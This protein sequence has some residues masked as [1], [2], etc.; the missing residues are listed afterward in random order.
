MNIYMVPNKKRREKKWCMK[1]NTRGR[2]GIL[3]R[4]PEKHREGELPA[5]PLNFLH[6]QIHTDTSARTNRHVRSDQSLRK[7]TKI[8][9]LARRRRDHGRGRP[10]AE[11]REA[12]KVRHDE[13]K[14]HRQVNLVASKFVYGSKSGVKMTSRGLTGQVDHH[15]T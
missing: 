5:E 11:S 8:A 13:Q 6:I 14:A 1:K 15:F 9:R 10:P 7:K 2:S 3:K 12:S 4:R